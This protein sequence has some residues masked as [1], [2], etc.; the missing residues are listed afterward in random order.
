MDPDQTASLG[1]VLIR[2]IVFAF[3]VKYSL[4][5]LNICSR[6]YKQIAFSEQKNIDRLRIYLQGF[7]P[8]LGPV[9]NFFASIFLS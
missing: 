5:C 8:S 2:F 1:A 6:H 7:S 9:V 4:V 3:R